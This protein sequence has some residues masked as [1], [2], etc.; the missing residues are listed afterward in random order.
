M[1]AKTPAE[2]PGLVDERFNSG[3][4]DQML[5]LYEDGAAFL[6]PGGEIL[7]GEA[8]RQAIGGFLSTGAKL[9]HAEAQV[10]E[11]GDIALITSPWTLSGGTGPDGSP[12]ELSGVVNAVVR[13]QPDG[14][15]RVV[16]DSI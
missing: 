8:M 4:L 6:P 13:R 7:R 5:E 1:A 9:M 2:M 16:I 14:R 3:D 10:I 12:V 11:A 15:W